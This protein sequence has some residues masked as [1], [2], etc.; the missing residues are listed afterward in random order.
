MS[1]KT[2]NS[3]S[4]SVSFG[5]GPVSYIHD[6]VSKKLRRGLG[7]RN[8][9]PLS[10]EIRNAAS[11]SLLVYFTSER[12]LVDAEPVIQDEYGACASRTFTDLHTVVTP[13]T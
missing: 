10:G 7:W 2:R 4:G 6:N 1:F 11:L 9:S 5:N 8:V 12:L 13:M 3:L